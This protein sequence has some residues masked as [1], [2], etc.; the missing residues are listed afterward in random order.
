MILAAILFKRKKL[1]NT[2]LWNK[3]CNVDFHFAQFLLARSLLVTDAAL[4]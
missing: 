3:N 1:N 2:V 4:E